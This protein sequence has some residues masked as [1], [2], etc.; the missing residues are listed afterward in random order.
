MLLAL[1]E[2][3]QRIIVD[4]VGAS[5]SLWVK[6]RTLFVDT[7][8]W[9]SSY[10]K[11]GDLQSLQLATSLGWIDKL[12]I[13]PVAESHSCFGGKCY[14]RSCFENCSLVLFHRGPVPYFFDEE[15]R[16]KIEP[17]KEAKPSLQEPEPYTTW[18]F[19][20]LYYWKSWDPQPGY[21]PLDHQ[22]SFSNGWE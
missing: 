21:N 20:D 6:N 15:Y 1:P 10:A 16:H 8:S 19:K 2:D 7:N 3:L 4:K 18:P 11:E 9:E 14:K 5:Y 22:H 12:V 13:V 17:E